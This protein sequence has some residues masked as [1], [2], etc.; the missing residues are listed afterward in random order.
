MKKI[1]SDDIKLAA[2]TI[3]GLSMDQV[4]KANSGH[5]GMPMGMADVAAVLWL[6]H[7]EHDPSDPSWLNR[8]RFVL[9]AGHGSALLYSLLHL[10]GYDLPMS[11]LES[12]RQW[13][14]KTPGHPEYS[15]TPGVETTTGPLGQGCGNAVGMALAE[16]MLASRF[17]TTDNEIMNHYTYVVCGDGDLMEGISHEAFSLAG[18][19]KLNKL[20]ALYDS[21]KISIE[22]STDLAFTDD[23][24][25]LFQG[26]NW[27]VLETDA[28]DCDQIDRMI[29]KAR[30][31]K[32]KPTIIICRSNIAQ[33][34]PN[35]CGSADSHGAPL[36]EDEIRATKRNIGLPENSTFHVPDAVR[37]MF[38]ERAAKITRKARKW[39]K[40]LEKHLAD[41][42]DK[43]KKWNEYFGELPENIDLPEF[44][45]QKALAT[46]SASG[47]VIQSLAKTIPNLVGGSADLAPSNKSFIDG[48]ASIA[49]GSYNGRNLHFGVREH[50]M[51]SILNGM[52]LHGGLRVYGATFF[53]FADYCR[54]SIRLACLMKLP[55]TYV[56][57]HD[58][59]YV[60]EDGPTHEP[61][62]HMASLRCMPNM[63]VIRP[64]DPT[65]T[66]QAWITA[67]KNKTGP[68]ALLLTRQNLPV[69]NRQTY[70]PASELKKGAYTLC[71]SGTG[72]PEL[73]IMASGSEVSL[74]LEAFKQLSADKNIRVVSMPSWELFEKQSPQY[75]DSILPP[76]CGKRLAIEAG[77]SMGWSKY[78][79][80][81]GKTL[82]I[83]HFGASAPYKVLA[84]KFGFT[85]DN[86]LSI[87]K[88]ML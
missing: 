85:L 40:N 28:H 12:F 46:R 39:K 80:K 64:A 76:S 69:L 50:G 8:D 15:H 45:P 23:A 11:E 53:V 62:E 87:I 4:Q 74:A 47:K 6:K 66:A 44:D 55:I 25:K 33:G 73:I 88:E 1:T 59:F 17:N 31:Q 82:C 48:E 22:G 78:T 34:S 49:P 20:I 35:K 54:P 13:N 29:K 24:K 14:S 16:R 41:Q 26:F 60:G 36:G 2:N 37:A 42:P 79:G 71:Q 38:K 68:T 9:S 81:D 57:T 30:R 52:A 61:I 58:S 65:E 83:D 19:L 51:C 75:K 5:P 77:S 86:T 10:S 21:N 27:N 3:R 56:F 43:A 7:L 72:D 32:D 63:T 70:P 84:E 67:L 18:H